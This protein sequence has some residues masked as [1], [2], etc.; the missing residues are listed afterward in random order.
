MQK[1]FQW[2]RNSLKLNSTQKILKAI[3][4]KLKVKTDQLLSE[5]E[6]SKLTDTPY[7]TLCQQELW[8]QKNKKVWTKLIALTISFLIIGTTITKLSNIQH[9]L[10]W[11]K[12]KNI[13]RNWKKTAQ[14]KNSLFQIGLLTIGLV[15]NFLKTFSATVNHHAQVLQLITQRSRIH[16]KKKRVRLSNLIA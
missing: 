12:N 6:I 9:K 14:A 8:L 4:S 3:L 10:K 1:D 7:L 11:K 2:T 16:L 15:P 5:L 13:L